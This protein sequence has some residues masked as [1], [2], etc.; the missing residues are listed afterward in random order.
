M[1][2]VDRTEFWEEEGSVADTL[3]LLSETDAGQT[4]A[5]KPQSSGDTDY[6]KWVKLICESQPI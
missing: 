3:A 5:D 2:V 4:H 6:Q 1:G